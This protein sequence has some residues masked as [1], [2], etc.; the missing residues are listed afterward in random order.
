MRNN[1]L[2]R[3]LA[4]DL[5]KNMRD[6]CTT[7]VLRR[8]DAV[9]VNVSEGENGVCRQAVLQPKPPPPAT[10]FLVKKWVL[11]VTMTIGFL[12]LLIVLLALGYILERVPSP[13]PEEDSDDAYCQLVGCSKAKVDMKNILRIVL[14]AILLLALSLQGL[15]IWG[16]AR[17]HLGL[18][19]GYTVLCVLTTCSMLISAI[20]D[21]A[22]KLLRAPVPLLLTYV[23]YSYTNDLRIMRNNRLQR[24]LAVV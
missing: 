12:C 17:Q 9:N 20:D 6:S 21:P 18:C 13:S 19:V 7:V 2:Q 1:R 4:V 24:G 22:T 5:R 3:G 8:L 11:L 23:A 14:C 15:F 16:V 10:A